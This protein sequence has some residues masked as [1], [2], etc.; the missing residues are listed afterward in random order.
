[1]AYWKTLPLTALLSFLLVATAAGQD[2]EPRVVELPAQWAVGT[3]F[4]VVME[5]GRR[6]YRGDK[7]LTSAISTNYISVK[8]VAARENGFV[9][10]WKFTSIDMPPSAT[11][12][13]L[14]GHLVKIMEGLVVRLKTDAYGTVEEVGN[15]KQV[16]AAI[17]K[18]CDRLREEL[19]GTSFTETTWLL[20]ME[21]MIAA[22]LGPELSPTLLKEPRLFTLPAGGS[23]TLGED[24]EFA[25][26]L[27]FPMTGELIPTQASLR[28]DSVDDDAGTA[29]ILWKQTLDP[30]AAKRIVGQ[31]V[32]NI[33]QTFGSDETA[34]TVFGEADTFDIRDRGHYTYNLA[35]GLPEIMTWARDTKTSGRHP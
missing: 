3:T 17:R 13:S 27:P 16:R 8:V 22:M 14:I 34:E 12:I 15:Q 21:P 29:V 31:Y 28:L 6:K 32:A 1:V 4:D 23:Y 19:I 30:E 25:D 7:L 9:F 5:K 26:A 35:T 10:R 20:V 2:T 24:N 18:K 33:A 11:D